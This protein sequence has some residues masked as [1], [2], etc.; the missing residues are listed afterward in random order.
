MPSLAPSLLLSMP[1]MN[2]PNFERTVVLLCQHS[3]EGAFGLVVNRPVVTTAKI[4][5]ASIR[6]EA[7][8]TSSDLDWRSGRARAKLD[9]PAR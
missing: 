5:A 6:N 1:Q 9:P 8:N 2:D 4:V 3:A 7:P